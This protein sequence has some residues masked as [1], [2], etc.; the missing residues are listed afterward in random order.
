MKTAGRASSFKSVVKMYQEWQA[1]CGAEVW[2]V[3]VMDSISRKMLND[4]F[5]DGFLV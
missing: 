1:S 3:N 2:S 5:H 4:C